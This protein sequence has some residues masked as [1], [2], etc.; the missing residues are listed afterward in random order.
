MRAPFIEVDPTSLSQQAVETIPVIAESLTVHK[1]VADAGGVRLQKR[2]H[3]E[4]VTVDEPLLKQ[5]VQL[6]RVPI[7][8]D[9]DGP[10][11]IRYEDNVTIIPVVEERLIIRRQLV[12]VEEIHI[13]RTQHTDRAPQSVTV[14]R[15]EVIV[16]RQ[17]TEVAPWRVERV[18]NEPND[19]IGAEPPGS[20]SQR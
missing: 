9:V 12:L 2:V 5:A 20:P 13:A 15:E 4:V 10:V 18:G 17:D 11:A 7:G 8:R 14:R 19:I 16:E 6:T 3:E 1:T